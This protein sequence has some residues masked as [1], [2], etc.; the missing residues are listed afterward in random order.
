MVVH[1]GAWLFGDE[2]RTRDVCTCLVHAG[3]VACAANYRLGRIPCGTVRQGLW[4]TTVGGTVALWAAGVRGLALVLFVALTAV[5][6]AVYAIWQ[7]E[8]EW[9]PYHS[10]DVSD[11]LLWVRQHVGPYGGDAARVVLLGHSAGAH[12]AT[13]AAARH[14]RHASPW[15]PQWLRG[16][17]CVSGVFSHV[18]IQDVTCGDWLMRAAFGRQDDFALDSPLRAAHAALPPHLLLSATWDMTLLRHAWDYVAAL[19]GLG[20]WAR[21]ATFRGTHFSLMKHWGRGEANR[22]V[23]HQILGFIRSVTQCPR[24]EWCARQPGSTEQTKPR[25]AASP[26]RARP[27]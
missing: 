9:V 3:Y 22:A 24:V 1:G 27:A 23:L 11:A 17:V 10:H 12:L 2:A 18:R 25:L 20:V 19:R 14:L 4:W 5:A 8:D 15:R 16:V 6:W 26:G 13:L 21:H 7:W